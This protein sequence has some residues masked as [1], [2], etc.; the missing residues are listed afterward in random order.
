M[1]MWCWGE[2]GAGDAPPGRK[3][4][5]VPSRR[6]WAGG[7]GCDHPAGA[8]CRALGVVLVVSGGAGG[9][10][11]ASRVGCGAAA[12]DGRAVG[13][14]PSLAG[15]AAVWGGWDGPAGRGGG[16]GAP[17]G[18]VMGYESFAVEP[19]ALDRLAA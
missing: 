2:S 13:R 1:W 5:V 8:G 6:V 19:A 9:R 10:V 18:A 3:V 17:D 16:G 11:R 7:G 12:P 15:I 4:R 14:G